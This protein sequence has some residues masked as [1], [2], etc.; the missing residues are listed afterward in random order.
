MRTTSYFER[1]VLENPERPD[2]TVELCERVVK[3][4]EHTEEQPDGRLHFWG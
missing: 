4:A 2:I 3:E 1:R